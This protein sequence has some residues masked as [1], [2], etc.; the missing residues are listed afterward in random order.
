[1]ITDDYTRPWSLHNGVI[2]DFQM[3]V[4]PVEVV[5]RQCNQGAS[6]PTIN[7]IYERR[8]LHEIEQEWRKRVKKNCKIR[9]VK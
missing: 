2:V 3:R 7:G 4:V 6:V 8:S 1:M 9:G 5:L